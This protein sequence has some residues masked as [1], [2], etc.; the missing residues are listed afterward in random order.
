MFYVSF[1]LSSK[2]DRRK[3]RE[4]EEHKNVTLIWFK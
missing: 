2:L 1:G 3:V 4:E